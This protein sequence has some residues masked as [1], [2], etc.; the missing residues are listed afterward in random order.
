M[1][2]AT[3]R[4]KLNLRGETVFDL[5]GLDVP[6]S[7][8]PDAIRASTAV[9]LFEQT[10]CR[11]QP[12]FELQPD[13]LPATAGICR[14]VQGM[15]L[16]IILAASWIQ[17]LSVPDIADELRLSFDVLESDESNV[18]DRHRSI[19]VVFDHTLQRLTEVQRDVFMKLSVFRGG[20]TRDAAQHVADTSLRMLLNLVNKSL[21]ERD[22]EGRFFV[23]ELLRQYADEQLQT[24]PDAYHLTR[25]LHC[26]Y[27]LGFVAQNDYRIMDV[28]YETTLTELENIRV[29]WQWAVEQARWEMVETCMVPLAWFFDMHGGF[30]EAE[31]AL[32]RVAEALSH[33]S[34]PPLTTLGLAVGMRGWEKRRWD[35]EA[36]TALVR[37][38][39]AL[40]RQIEPGDAL[41][42]MLRELVPSV[43]ENAEKEQLLHESLV[44]SRTTGNQFNLAGAMLYQGLFIH[45]PEGDHNQ[46]RQRFVEALS[47]FRQH[48]PRWMTGIALNDLGQLEHSVGNYVKAAQ[49]HTEAL[50]IWP[51]ARTWP[52]AQSLV[53]LAMAEAKLGRQ[54]RA[55][56]HFQESLAIYEEIGWTELV[57]FACTA[58]GLT[59]W[60]CG[61]H[62]QASDLHSRALDIWRETGHSLRVANALVN[63]GHPTV[64]LGHVREAW[65]YY[66]EALNLAQSQD[67]PFARAIMAEVVM[68]LARIMGKTGDR[69][70]AV[71]YLSMAALVVSGTTWQQESQEIAAEFLAPLEAALAPD[72]YAAAV[73]CGKELD[74]DEVVADLLAMEF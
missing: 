26:D 73:E 18:P 48:G 23:H 46:A 11:L 12:T 55:H 4:E 5:T 15:P 70:Q 3:S 2:I 33:L 32:S 1:I 52:Y 10:A 63:L 30:R 19:R 37:Q 39:V 69:Q 35:D 67:D 7:D 60:H 57:A 61:E 74:L 54:D 13:D 72:D 9:Q 16:G 64:S 17:V 47:I 66:I 24:R 44:I 65:D 29:A 43:F 53:N 40:L 56:E 51:S 50:G 38:S 41:A 34:D 31:A 28:Y 36:G 8:D 45:G 71:A 49:H 20:F 62:G 42:F 22:P 25:D 14:L 6:A 68:G 27:Y 58:Y 21:L 59:L